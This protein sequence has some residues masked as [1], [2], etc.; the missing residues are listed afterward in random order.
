MDKQMIE[1]ERE[2]KWGCNAEWK[3]G[4]SGRGCSDSAG[5]QDAKKMSAVQDTHNHLG[6]PD[7]K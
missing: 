7:I 2:R 4:G 1:E 6:V 5:M 3:L